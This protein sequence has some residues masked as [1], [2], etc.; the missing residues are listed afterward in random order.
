MI[1]RCPLILLLLFLAFPIQGQD[2]I[3]ALDEVI[4][5][6][7]SRKLNPLGDIP[8]EVLTS[9]AIALNNPTD[10][11]GTINIVPGVYFLSGALNTNRITIRG[12]GAR[13]LFGTDKLRMY[14]NNIPVTNGT[15]T[16]TLEAFDLENLGA[17]RVIKGPKAGN[18]GAALGGALLLSSQEQGAQG[19]RMW[20]RTVTG[21]YGLFKNNLGLHYG[22]SVLQLTLRYNRLTTNGYRENNYFD[23]DGLLLDLSYKAGRRHQLGVLVNHIDY[24]AGIPS[25]LSRTAFEEDPTQAAFTWA[26]SRG[27]EANRY[28]LAGLSDRITLGN[29]LENITSLFL[30][31]L[32]HY[33]PR[34]FN[35]LDEYTLGYG[36]RSV[37][38]GRLGSKE[39]SGRFELGVEQYRDE[40]AWST[41]ENLYRENEGQGSLQGERLSRNR[42]FRT[43]AQWF[44]RLEL[45]LASSWRA[46]AS[47][48]LNKTT[49]E[50][51]DLFNNG[52]ANQ[53][54][55]R[56]FD[57][58]ILPGITLRYDPGSGS[59]AYANASRGFN[60][61]SLE[62]S[63][64]P[65]G[66]INPQISQEKGMNYELGGQLELLQR[67]LQIR[68]ALYWMEI[69][70]LLVADRVGEDQFIGR[71]AGSTR[72]RGLE[73]SAEY[74]RALSQNLR[75]NPFISY[76]LNAH[77][78]QDFV[79][80]DDDFSGNPLTGVPRNRVYGGFRLDTDA[81]GFLSLT[82]QYVDP[83][84]L[85][86][87]NTLNSE[88]YQLIN[89]QAGHHFNLLP[90]VRA[91]LDFGIN[92]LGNRRY[93]SSVL[94]N[95][96]S[97]NGSEP[98]YFYPGNARN[99][100]VSLRLDYGG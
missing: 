40:Y 8:S 57:P 21:S 20:N 6:V 1:K 49:Y 29:G 27:F 90:K 35:I 37:F 13:T 11:A 5:K 97:F 75:I 87:A 56:D 70:D 99:Y 54:G 41:F 67:A 91:R 81:G 36:L 26:Q 9:R 45:P 86:D 92:N 94:I 88:A 34:P 59:F 84:P 7:E 18:Y 24:R 61:P 52:A 77:R 42:E 69:K 23:R 12:V 44:G 68:G 15:G 43:Y 71:N 28:T 78:F 79:D 80:G 63:L 14:Y 82:W 33:E 89:L 31:Y 50:Y 93:A 4:L 72:H 96:G 83:I 98:R 25:S 58:I 73:V 100:F 2:S 32:D 39:N 64:N 3:I 19:F 16:S 51:Q 60:N 47:L 76:T 85:T 53:S 22:D 62:E 38:Q 74:R 46:T 48:G 55:E 30:S 66:V 95:A 65:D 10:F 17:I